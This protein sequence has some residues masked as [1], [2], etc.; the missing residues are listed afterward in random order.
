M[1]DLLI[2]IKAFFVSLFPHGTVVV[3]TETTGLV[4]GELLQVALVSG[5]GR[6]LFNKYIKPDI[7]SEWPEAQKINHISPQMVKHSRHIST[8]VPLINAYLKHTKSLI[9]YNHISFDL[10]ILKKIWDYYRSKAS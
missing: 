1:I 2:K 5:T 10:P 7:A 3:D 9:G 8:Y 6:V 4:N